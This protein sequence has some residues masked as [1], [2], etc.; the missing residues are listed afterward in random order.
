VSVH[1][2]GGG[3]QRFVRRLVLRVHRHETRDPN[4]YRVRRLP[5]NPRRVS[6]KSELYRCVSRPARWDEN[7][8]D[9]DEAGAD[10]GERMEGI[11]VLQMTSAA[12]DPVLTML[13]TVKASPKVEAPLGSPASNL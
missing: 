2:T 9:E 7:T 4:F 11:E 12:R 3:G 8:G 5:A 10:D 6:F 13:A 1:K